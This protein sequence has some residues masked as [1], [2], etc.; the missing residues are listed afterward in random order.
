MHAQRPVVPDAGR[1]ARSTVPLL[2]HHEGG[3]LTHIWVRPHLLRGG[4]Q[5][6]DLLRHAD[7]LPDAQRRAR[8]PPFLLLILLLQHGLSGQQFRRGRLAHLL[9][10]FIPQ[11]GWL[12]LVAGHSL[13]VQGPVSDRAHALHACLPSLLVPAAQGRHRSHRPTAAAGKLCSQHPVRG[14]TARPGALTQVP[15]CIR[16]HH[17]SEAWAGGAAAGRLPP[18]K[19]L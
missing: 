6:T 4:N 19:G 8:Q 13:R 17:L 3:R 1:P 12:R 11:G 14:A 2:H 9:H 5:P 15:R 18:C 16:A 7:P 10:I